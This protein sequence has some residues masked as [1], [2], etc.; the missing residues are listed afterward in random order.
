[1]LHLMQTRS[2]PHRLAQIYRPLMCAIFLGLFLAYLMSPSLFAW[3][4][5]GPSITGAGAA[6]FVAGLIGIGLLAWRQSHPVDAK[7]GVRREPAG[8]QS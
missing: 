3:F 2:E 5:I 7:P 4:G 8:L 6:V 1:M